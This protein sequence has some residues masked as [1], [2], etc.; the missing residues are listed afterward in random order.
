MAV[1]VEETVPEGNSNTQHAFLTILDI[2]HGF[3]PSQIWTILFSGSI[4]KASMGNLM[5]NIWIELQ[6]VMS[7]P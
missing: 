1:P 3:I 6:G 4:N 7:I 5:K 2:L